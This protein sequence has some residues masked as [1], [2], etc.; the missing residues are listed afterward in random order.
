LVEA[1]AGK[2]AGSNRIF[3]RPPASRAARF[4]FFQDRG[5]KT[6]KKI[7]IL[8]TGCQK[9]TKLAENAAQAAAELGLEH[10]IVKVTDLNRIMEFGVMLTPALAVDGQVLAS[11]K[12]MSVAEIKKALQ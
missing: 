1:G 12:V 7:Q 6:M 9:C 4:N 2:T 8:G 11:G 3:P 10:E 5:E